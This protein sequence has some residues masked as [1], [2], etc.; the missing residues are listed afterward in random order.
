MSEAEILKKIS[1]AKNF[2]EICEIAKDCTINELESAVHN[3]LTHSNYFR[4]NLKG[5]KK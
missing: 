2:D 4:L 3:V 1:K 5:D